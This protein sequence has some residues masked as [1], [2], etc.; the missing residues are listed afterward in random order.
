MAEKLETYDFRS[1]V[2]QGS[3]YPWDEWLDGG[4][5]KLRQGEDFGAEPK[6]FTSSIFNAAKK[7][8]KKVNTAVDGEYV[9][10]RAYIPE[11]PAAA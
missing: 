8:G 7:R 9:V 4:Y 11:A 6:N 3:R 10:V 1:R 5:W 2:G